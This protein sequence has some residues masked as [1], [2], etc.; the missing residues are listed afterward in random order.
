MTKK[1]IT[2]FLFVTICNF[3]CTLYS[4][5]NI[6]VPSNIKLPAKKKSTDKNTNSNSESNS[7]TSSSGNTMDA[8]GDKQKIQEFYQKIKDYKQAIDYFDN[9]FEEAGSNAWINQ[10]N[11]NLGDKYLVQ[12]K[13]IDSIC[14][15][16]YPGLKNNPSSDYYCK[17]ELICGTA[18]AAPSIVSNSIKKSMDKDL[19]FYLGLIDDAIK[20]LSHEGW[21]SPS[22]NIAYNLIYDL[23]KGKAD[24]TKNLEPKY[25]AAGKT[26]PANFF[27]PL[28][29][30]LDELWEKVD[31]TA[32]NYSFPS[33]LSHDEKIGRAHV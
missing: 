17:P 26:I 27:D 19:D 13:T 20:G 23:P 21:L 22:G 33:G 18:S 16:E 30:K 6:K 5:I 7:N 29:K 28:D 9:A 32:P 11:Q 15:N 31:Q 4:Q 8:S 10:Y 25:T 12:L 1:I 14:K 2:I 3:P 24:I